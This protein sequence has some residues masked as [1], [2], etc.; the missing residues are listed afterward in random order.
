MAVLLFP[1]C[2]I[3]VHIRG[4]LKPFQTAESSRMFTSCEPSFQLRASV[5]M[6][7]CSAQECPVQDQP[8]IA[9][10]QERKSKPG[11]AGIG[12]F[13][14]DETQQ[15]LVP[16]LERAGKVDVRFQG[17]EHDSPR[18]KNGE[19]QGGENGQAASVDGEKRSATYPV[20]VGFGT[21]SSSQ[22]TPYWSR[23]FV[24]GQEF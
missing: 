10:R 15:P 20:D 3:N 1:L 11:E 7:V 8:E 4:K 9:F 22:K 17:V 23:L 24:S 13:E 16:G 19:N 5:L 6:G 14:L 21:G 2:G 12:K 18:L